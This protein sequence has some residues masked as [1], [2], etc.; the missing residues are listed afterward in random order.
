MAI[1]LAFGLT[2]LRY[3]IGQL[4]HAGPG[5]FPALV[6]G[7]LMIIAVATVVRSFFVE[8][9]HLPLFFRNI[10]IVLGSLCGFALVSMFVNMIVGIVFLVFVSTLA[11]TSYSW[12]RNVKISAGLIAMAL[13]L[14]YLLGLNL[15]LF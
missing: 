12:W 7:L 15:P 2:A 6:S 4:S 9:V 10:L 11:G 5:F 13:A 1:A 3:P 14:Q 8:K